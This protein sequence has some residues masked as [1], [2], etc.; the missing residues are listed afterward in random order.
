MP[1][2]TAAAFWPG[3]SP[4]RRCRKGETLAQLPGIAASIA[5]IAPLESPVSARMKARTRPQAASFRAVSAAI[6]SSAPER[7]R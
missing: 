6:A 5:T 2:F 4:G 1:R 3:W 7:S